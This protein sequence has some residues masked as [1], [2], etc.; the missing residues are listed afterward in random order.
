MPRVL[1]PDK[2]YDLDVDIIV[3]LTPPQHHYEINK[4]FWKVEAYLYTEK[5]LCS[6]LS[7]AREILDLAEKKN[8]KV[9]CAPDTFLSANIQTAKSLSKMDG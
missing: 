9:G 2:V 6:T 5:P 8:L 7:E 3:N 1:E 4:R